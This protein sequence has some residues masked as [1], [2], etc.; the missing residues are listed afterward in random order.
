MPISLPM[1][2]LALQFKRNLDRLNV[3]NKVNT[4]NE[5]ALVQGG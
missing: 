2:L 1:R 4:N 5:K 3:N